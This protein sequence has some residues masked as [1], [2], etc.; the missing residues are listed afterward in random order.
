VRPLNA[1]GEYYLTDCPK[2]L[3]SRGRTVIA[4]A[5]LNIQE[6]MGVNTRQQLAEVERVMIS[7]G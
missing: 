6:A 3:K 4:A 7:G 2:I 5:Q 1:Q